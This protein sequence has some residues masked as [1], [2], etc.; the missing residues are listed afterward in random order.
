LATR[1]SGSSDFFNPNKRAPYSSVNF[2]TAHDGFTLTDLVSYLER[3]NWANG[4]ENRD[5]HGHNLSVNFG[6]EGDSQDA[7]VGEHRARSRRVLLANVVFSL[8]TPMLLAGDEMGHS[9]HGNNNAY[10]QD[11]DTTWLHWDAMDKGL[12]QYTRQLIALRK[13]CS[14]LQSQSWWH[15]D[16][17]GRGTVARW[18]NTNGCALT[19][20]DWTA[21]NARAFMLTLEQEALY[22]MLCNAGD[23]AV[24]C[25]LPTGTW[26]RRLDTS[27]P[28]FL[29]QAFSN[30]VLLPAQSLW[31]LEFSEN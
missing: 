2:V 19:A 7:L 5:G 25:T 11:N 16:A 12:L 14:A 3:C 27:E 26:Q 9:Q 18:F 6:V 10:C 17:N 1:L 24:E 8:G 4:E 21:S 30:T 23:Q 20:G 29:R 13:E 22:V 31:I 28:S 15:T